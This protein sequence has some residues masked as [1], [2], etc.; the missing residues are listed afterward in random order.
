MAYSTL[1]DSLTESLLNAGTE[2]VTYL[3][4]LLTAAVV[5]I[6]GWLIARLLKAV[7][8]RVVKGLDNLWHKYIVRKEFAEVQKRYPPTIVI[9]EVVF[10]FL[11]LLFA[12]LAADVLG[13][14]VFVSWI[15]QV[16]SFF[17]VLIAGVVIIVAGTI[18]SSIM[19]DFV[20]GAAI[21]AGAGQAELL[22]RVTQVIILLT[23]IVIGIDQMGIEIT[24]LSVM[25][26]IILSA[27]LGAVALAFGFGAKKH[28]ANIIAGHNVRKRYR[29][30]DSIRIREIEGKIIRM[31]SSC[32]VIDT[33]E[34]EVSVPASIFDSE[35]AYLIKRED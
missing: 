8:S 5:I 16:V 29:T 23:A 11:M 24:F 30:G 27:T 10:W 12:S 26:A 33:A 13:L 18:L 7:M 4:R 15:S 31:E 14:T 2:I 19:R 34:G 35:S 21:S 22:G 3:P 20:A 6:A 17:P 1:L 9:G 32:L 28:V 25:A